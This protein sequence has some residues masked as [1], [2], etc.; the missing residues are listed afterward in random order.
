[1][2]Q[3]EDWQVP[4]AQF[5][6][7]GIS[8]D[9]VRARQQ[10][11]RE[12][13]AARGLDAVLV[14]G[15][16]FYD[17]P[18]NLAYL[19]NH[20]PPFP[21]SVFADGMRGLGHGF[22][23][24]PM[25]GRP[26]LLADGRAY[27]KDMVAVA[28]VRVSNDLVAPLMDTLADLGL[29]KSRLG[30]AGEDI[31]PAVVARELTRAL[32][33]LHL[34]PA[35][36]LLAQQRMHKSTAEV[37]LLSEAAALAGLGL[38]TALRHVQPGRKEWDVCAAGTAAALAAGAD[39]VR[40][41]RVHSGPLAG[42]GSR[43]PQATDRVL[44]PGDMVTL[45]IIGAWWGYQFDVLR[46][47]AVG[48]PDAEQRRVLDAALRATERVLARVRPGA[49]VDELVTVALRSLADDGYEAYTSGF[50]GHG[51]GLE[52][53]EEP[54]LVPGVRLELEEG[55]VLCVEPSLRIPGWGGASIEQE[56]VV[57]HDGFELLT[58]FPA[59]LW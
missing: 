28:E 46:S 48:A 20:F 51:I 44:Q 54:Y 17:R 25:A 11:T 2:K 15:R 27:R 59:R 37:R 21:A 39:F 41:L 55:M 40:Y 7:S 13:A 18:G 36:D 19:T 32:P 1:V 52:T 33:E 10:R 29:A 56:I 43:W 38:Q 42:Q 45:D 58:D 6:A 16:S 3:V 53:V 9:E 34:V 14:V 22:L 31:L 26:V 4:I 35:D 47:T 8:P 49:V 23:V 50:V 24:L 12:L 57:T 30:V 5:S